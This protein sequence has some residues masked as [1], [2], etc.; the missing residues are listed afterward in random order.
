MENSQIADI[1]DRIADLIELQGGNQFRIRSYRNAA[2]TVR[3]MTDRLADLDKEDKDLST[4]PNIGDKTADKIH[5]ILEKG[6]CK[7]LEDLK[8]EVPE[9]L[10]ELMKVPNLGPKKAMKLHEE[11]GVSSLEELR[12]AC[13]EGKVRHVPN[14]GEK[15]EEKILQGL[16]TLGAGLGRF[17][18]KDARDYVDSL[19]KHLDGCE[20]LERY[21]IAGS[22]R[23][24]KET[25]GDLDV[26]IEATDRSTAADEILE[27]ENIDSVDSKGK[28]KLTV[29]L[30]GNMQVDFRFFESH[31]FGAAMMYFTGSKAHN[32]A[33]RRRAIDR[34]WKLNEYGLFKGDVGGRKQQKQKTDAR[35]AGSDEESLYHRLN[36][37]W[38]PPEL[39][40]DRGEID[41]A[42]EDRLPK[43]ITLDDI[44]GDLQS[45]STESDGNE[46]VSD[47]AAA[48][49]DRGLQYL[50]V[51]DHSKRVTMAKGLDNDRCR[52]HAE[53]I[54]HVNAGMKDFWL[55]AGIEVDI[56]KS[57]KLDLDEDV[58]ADLDWVIA[59]IHYDRN[60]SEKDMTERYLSAI[61]SGV[62]HALAH[63]LGRIIG[64]R[65]PISFD[66]DKVFQACKDHDVIV[67]INAAPDRLDLPDTYVKRAKEIGLT[68]SIGTDAHKFSD[69]D[70]MPFGIDVARRGWL[71]KGDVVN[72]LTAKQL[73]KRLKRD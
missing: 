54:R 40:E 34:D 16:K 49:R 1:F 30:S 51:T 56:L 7:R 45:H 6:T 73:K 68:I 8:D 18:L 31:S 71:E 38:V 33:L 43:L 41:A 42:A 66:V 63:P 46:S 39:R 62:V 47:M 57:G 53:H 21:E 3:D 61:K 23:R 25:V 59:S 36:L 44:R 64:R 12:K 37:K 27:Y 11:L 10:P 20:A 17:L 4:L 70:F 24:R 28:E 67:E 69:L 15:T 52:K 32:I 72:T 5:E 14:M 48:A 29:R 19:K 26:L 13:E 58:L 50:A 65:D 55:L 2:R 60:L 9:G 22:Y 35:L